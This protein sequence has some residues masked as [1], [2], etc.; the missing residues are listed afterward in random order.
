MMNPF[1]SGETPV[2]QRLPGRP[3]K[4]ARRILWVA[5]LTGLVFFWGCAFHE[6]SRPENLVKL[7]GAFSL[8]GNKPAPAAWW[9][10]LGDTRL[11]AL[12][13]EALS[14]NMSLRST[15]DR[16]AQARAS[17]RREGAS[18]WPALEGTAGATGSISGTDGGSGSGASTSHGLTFSGAL[19]ASYEVDLWGRVRSAQKAAELDVLAGEQDLHA[20]AMTLSAEVAN[21]WIRLQELRGRRALLEEQLKTNEDYVEAVTLRFRLGR[22]PAVDVLQQRQSLE[23]VRGER[24]RVEASIRVEENR[25]AVLL[26]KPPGTFKAPSGSALPALP[27]LPSTGAPAE[28]VQRRPDLQAAF[29]RIRAA[30]RRVSVAIADRFPRIS[31]SART[32]GSAEVCDLFTSWLANLAANLT[33]P[34]LDGGRRKAEVDRA[35]ASASERL[36]QYG[37]LLLRSLEEVENAL[38]REARQKEY[39]GSLAKQI[40]FSRQ[41]VDQA[42]EGYR[43]GTVDF[44][45]FLTTV[46]AHQ[47]LERTRLQGRRDLVLYRIA[48]YR[49]LGGSWDLPR[50]PKDP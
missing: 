20:S 39:A 38:V 43:K 2:S 26:G 12:I 23:A 40:G 35:R 29:F 45:R 32:G 9:T 4:V 30:D 6:P 10:A 5:I 7:P 33:A 41:A 44:T 25:L 15:W 1:R 42:L 47:R 14:G 36:H 31:L 37:E 46:L 17:A 24:S 18:S 28:W 13:D 50:P 19:A 22:V 48:L 8:S 11:N 16:L 3:G 34:L 49:S 21:A 27:P